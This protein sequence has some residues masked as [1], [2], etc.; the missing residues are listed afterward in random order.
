MIFSCSHAVSNYYGSLMTKHLKN[1]E[2]E[3]SQNNNFSVAPEKIEHRWAAIH[4]P[5]TTHSAGIQLSIEDKISTLTGIQKSLFNYII[6]LTIKNN[7]NTTPPVFTSKIVLILG[8]PATSFKTALYKLINKGLIKKTGKRSRGGYRV[9]HVTNK[10]KNLALQ[11]RHNEDY[12]S[13]VHPEPKYNNRNTD[14]YLNQLIKS[15]KS[16]LDTRMEKIKQLKDIEFK[17]WLNEQNTEE[18]VKITHSERKNR[19]S[20]NEDQSV[21]KPSNSILFEYFEKNI[22]AGIK[23]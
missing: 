18:I 4:I 8:C 21:D 17:L 19:E 20:E 7:S 5:E 14:A 23:K 12:S 10:I 2:L 16:H 1:K 13:A 11:L 22:W 3:A 9:F 6:D 15:R